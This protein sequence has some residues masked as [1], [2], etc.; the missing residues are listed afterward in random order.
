MRY[1][2]IVAVAALAATTISAFPLRIRDSS[3]VNLIAGNIFNNLVKRF[4]PLRDDPTI[5]S[6]V[7]DW[8]LEANLAIPGD[9]FYQESNS[10]EV[11]DQQ[12]DNHPEIDPQE[13]DDPEVDNQGAD[14]MFGT[15]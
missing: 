2:W 8:A 9:I 10:Q 12:V 14:T 13:V 5:D 15:N 7:F 11:D 4:R 3:N 1:T 6:K